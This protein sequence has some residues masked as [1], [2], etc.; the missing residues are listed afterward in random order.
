MA[1]KP[2]AQHFEILETPEFF[3]HDGVELARVATADLQ[4]TA[5]GVRYSSMDDGVGE[6]SWCL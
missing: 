5:V 2:E 4:D 3:L 1:S 6:L